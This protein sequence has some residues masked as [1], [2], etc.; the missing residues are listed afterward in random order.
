MI[1]FFTKAYFFCI[2]KSICMWLSLELDPQFIFWNWALAK[3]ADPVRIR[4]RNT[5]F[6]RRTRASAL[7]KNFP[8]TSVVDP[9]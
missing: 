8:L 3:I 1:V 5:G 9:K 2:C 4:I 7:K 6:E